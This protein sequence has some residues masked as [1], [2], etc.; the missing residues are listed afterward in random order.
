MDSGEA[1]SDRVIKDILV[2]DSFHTS[3]DFMITYFSRDKLSLVKP[4]R[5][6]QQGLNLG[7]DD[8]LTES[9][10]IGPALKVNIFN[11]P[12]QNTLFAVG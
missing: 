5:I 9:I 7:Y 4:F 1:F 2:Q 10:Q 6:T 8:I 3:Q 11:N 12:R